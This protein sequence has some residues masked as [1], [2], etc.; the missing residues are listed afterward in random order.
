MIQT[1]SNVRHFEHYFMELGILIHT[2]EETKGNRFCFINYFF[3][4]SVPQRTWPGCNDVSRG[5][6]NDNFSH[7]LSFWG[8]RGVGWELFMFCGWAVFQNCTA[9]TLWFETLLCQYNLGRSRDY[10][11]E[12]NDLYMTHAL[13]LRN[14]GLSAWISSVQKHFLSGKSC[15]KLFYARGYFMLPSIHFIIKFIGH[16]Y[17]NETEYFYIYILR[18]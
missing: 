9:L 7:F 15:G 14:S 8:W 10:K 17:K 4:S 1:I 5:D 13:H 2:M 6:R 16:Q 3:S 11:T 12:N 18:L